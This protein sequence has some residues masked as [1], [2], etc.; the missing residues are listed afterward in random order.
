MAM[1]DF[2]V[3]ETSICQ[4][5]G[6]PDGLLVS[7]IMRAAPIYEV[8]DW[9]QGTMKWRSGYLQ[10]RGSRDTRDLICVNPAQNGMAFIGAAPNARLVTNNSLNYWG[11]LI[12]A[13]APRG[14]VFAI[15]L[16]DV[17]NPRAPLP[18][19]GWAPNGAFGDGNGFKHPWPVR[20]MEAKPNEPPAPKPHGTAR[21]AGAILQAARAP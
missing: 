20:P 16:S 18:T 17:A 3:D 19:P 12:V 13:C 7:L 9:N 15:T 6:P 8:P 5:I 10:L 14:G 2:T 11:D 1:F 4:T 21:K